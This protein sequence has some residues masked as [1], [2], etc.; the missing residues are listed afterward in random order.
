MI[1]LHIWFFSLENYSLS[2]ASYG[3]VIC[4]SDC[5][6]T[7]FEGK[8]ETGTRSGGGSFPRFKPTITS[9]NIV[10]LHE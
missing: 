5:T 9:T 10:R 2:S 6:K 3:G 1:K 7:V 4:H 8:D